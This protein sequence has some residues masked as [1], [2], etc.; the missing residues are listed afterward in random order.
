VEF[1]GYVISGDRIRMDLYKVQTIVDR[2]TLISI[3]DVQCFIG[4]ANF[5]QYFIA[6]YSL[7]T[8]FFIRLTRKDQP[9]F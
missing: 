2:A 5:Y 6:H 4:F 1:L 7:I 9:F 3:Q 8:A